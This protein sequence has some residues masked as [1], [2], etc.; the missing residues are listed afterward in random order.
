VTDSLRYRRC[1]GVA[2]FFGVFV[3]VVDGRVAGEGFE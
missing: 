3:A 1:I 2:P